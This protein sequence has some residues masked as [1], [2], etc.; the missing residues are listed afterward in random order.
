MMATSMAPRVERTYRN[1]RMSRPMTKTSCGVVP[2]EPSR[3]SWTGV[4]EPGVTMW[5]STRPTKV[6]NRPMP[7]EMA[8]RSS[9]GTAR[10]SASRKPVSTSRVM[11]MPSMTIM[12]IVRGQVEFGAMT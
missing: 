7:T 11:M 12:P 6:M 2:S 8:T 9:R 1:S 4:P 10:K 3:P 5:A